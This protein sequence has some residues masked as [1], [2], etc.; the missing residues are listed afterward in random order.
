MR[1]EGC[2]HPAVFLGRISKGPESKNDKST[3]LGEIYELEACKV[4]KREIYV[5]ISVQS[6]LTLNGRS[7]DREKKNRE[8]CGVTCIG[9]NEADV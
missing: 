5:Y 9:W 6:T 2:E 8:R 3:R 4:E 1:S 7:R